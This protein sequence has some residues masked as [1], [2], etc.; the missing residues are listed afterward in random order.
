[1]EIFFYG[2]PYAG[3]SGKIAKVYDGS[4]KKNK[5]QRRNV[6]CVR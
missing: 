4:F 6:I 3:R 1:M 2:K 5:D